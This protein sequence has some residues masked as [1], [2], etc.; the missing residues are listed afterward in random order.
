MAAINKFS[1]FIL[2]LF[3]LIFLAGSCQ[4]PVVK[5]KPNVLLIVVD[6]LRPELSCYGTKAI[7][8]NI[9]RLASEG[10]Q[11]NRAYCNVPV[12]G[13]S[14]ASLFTGTRPTR[15]RFRSYDSAAE[16]DFPEA[17][18]LPAFLKRNG[19]YTIARS[20]V[21]GFPTDSDFSWNELWSP[22][23]TAF[24]WRDYF[25]PENK[26]LDS[27]GGFGFGSYPFECA[28]VD[29]TAYFDGKAI[30][31]ACADL[32]RMRKTEKSFFLAVGL[33]KPHLPFN[34]P[35]KYWDLY[36][37]EQFN[38]PSNYRIENSEIPASAFH[39]W[40]ELRAYYGV[41]K[42]GSLPDSAAIK[43]I[44]GYYA[45]VSY[46]DNL[47][48]VLLDE[49]KNLGLD[50]NTIVVLIGDNGWNLGEHGLWCKHS[51]FETSLH[52]PLIVKVPGFPGGMQTNAITEY[53]DIY[54]TI[55]D[56]LRLE[57]PTTVEGESFLPVL[58]NPE[59][60]VKDY[61]I[62]KWHDG[63]TLVYNNYF[64]TEWR[65]EKDS[66]YSK[67]LFDH[68]SDPKENFNLADHPNFSSLTDSLAVKITQLRGKDYLQ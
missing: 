31:K 22:I 11:F 25:L 41:P 63:I 33:R 32:R 7:T 2:L 19:Y 28:E 55:C 34:A 18:T 52:V 66:V 56:L 21:F 37:E 8:P 44:H 60:K 35:K 53:I 67:M 6:D 64:Y 17:E 51:N 26:R 65:N 15:S 54:P 61:A 58:E 59:T 50:K 49:L 42:N 29:D 9:D 62:C 5:E 43:I 23:D 40:A 1:F 47:V 39:N 20:K 13:A 10:V 14:R 45:S 68:M 12:C 46:A 24:F 16:K 30:Q 57:K 4:K 27:I 36:D 38:L 48:G 3:V